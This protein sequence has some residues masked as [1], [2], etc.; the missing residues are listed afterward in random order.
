MDNAPYNKSEETM[1]HIKAL[2]MP[3]VFT[4]PY[5]FDASP[6][7]LFFAYLK[8]GLIQEEDVPIGKR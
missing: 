1:A 5:S 2:N 3:M 4:G 6:V 8:K 7:E